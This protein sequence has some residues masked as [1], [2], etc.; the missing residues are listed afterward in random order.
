MNFANYEQYNP[1]QQ[2][3]F[4]YLTM[5]GSGED[6]DENNVALSEETLQRIKEDLSYKEKVI[7][8]PTKKQIPPADQL[9]EQ[10]QKPTKPYDPLVEKSVIFELPITTETTEEMPT[11]DYSDDNSDNN[12]DDNSDD[13]H[14]NNN[15]QIPPPPLQMPEP[16]SQLGTQTMK[17]TTHVPSTYY[18]TTPFTSN[19]TTPS[20][21]N[22]TTP[23]TSNTTTPSTSQSSMDDNFN[24]LYQKQYTTNIYKLPLVF[25]NQ[26]PSFNNNTI[27]GPTGLYYVDHF[28]NKI[29]LKQYQREKWANGITGMGII[30]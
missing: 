17:L 20:T 8:S 6:E 29:Y 1:L 11:N 18:T 23:S 22:T 16:S 3:G 27:K 12:S 21:S 19:T 4:T 26:H 24:S 28:G 2:N 7:L 30:A 14:D 13:D 9:E 10:S 5:F 25:D 15:T